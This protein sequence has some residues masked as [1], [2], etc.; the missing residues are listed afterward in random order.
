MTNVNLQMLTK[1]TKFSGEFY[2]A[3]IIMYFIRKH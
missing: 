1:S 3:V 2:K